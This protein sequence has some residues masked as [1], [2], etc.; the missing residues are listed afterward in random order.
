MGKTRRRGK[1]RSE[2]RIGGREEIGG[3]SEVCRGIFVG[4]GI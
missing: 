4:G 2:K 3:D 1:R